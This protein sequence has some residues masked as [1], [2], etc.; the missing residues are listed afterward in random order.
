MNAAAQGRRSLPPIPPLGGAVTFTGS[1]R[2][3]TEVLAGITLV[4]LAVP[5]NIGYASVAGL[6][7]TV[8][9]YASILPVLVFACTT[10]SRRLVVGPDATVAALLAAAVLPVV[11]TGVAATQA[12]IAVAL[13]T[14]LVLMVG[15]LIGLGRLVR[16][17]SHAVLIGFIAGLAV[18]ILTSQVRRM[19]AIDVDAEGW[20]L[21]VIAMFAAVPQASLPSV[22]IGIATIVTVR[23]LR[24]LAPRV[25]GSLVALVAAGA[26][27]RWWQ[28]DGVAL[29]GPVPSGL[30]P[31]TFPTL[32]LSAWLA[33]L[34]VA[35]AIALLT[36]AE[37]VLISQNAARRNAE[38]LEPNGEVFAYGL[39]NA[40]AAVSGGMPI[41]ASASRTAALEDSGSQTQTPMIVAAGLAAVVAIAFTDLLAAIPMAA[42]GGLVANAVVGLVNVPAFRHLA[43][44]RRSEFLT[45]LL[46]AVGVLVLGPLP[47]LALAAVV[48]AVDV[49][50]RAA[51]LPWAELAGAPQPD[52]TGR[53]TRGGDTSAAAGLQVLRPEGPLFFANAHI[54][55][56][57]LTEAATDREVRWLV[58]DL[59]AVS[60]VDPTAADALREGLAAL[61][62][63]GTVVGLSRVRGPTRSL[64][65][66]YGLTEQVGAAQ[67]FD[68]NR[69]AAAAYIASR[70]LSSED[71]PQAEPGSRPPG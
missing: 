54:I 32:P 13:L 24:R 70:G 10:G 65:D 48:S 20:I 33:L 64:L 12:A 36:V 52:G 46:C 50:R 5:M 39:A 62:A 56:A 27:V 71:G 35:L 57:R 49:V 55:R 69:A 19:M 47:G 8:G 41:G 51:D 53:F 9:I 6:P 26:A 43:R 37:G 28:P 25:P 22:T 42:L 58:L 3:T 68:S 66:R 31:L 4:A 60:D 34:P 14:G 21:E 67:V 63:S 16:F 40:A 45:A 1:E 11:A 44:M 61:Q 15:W 29:L 7:A 2:L 18:D 38:T 17:L 30:P 59:E 23:V